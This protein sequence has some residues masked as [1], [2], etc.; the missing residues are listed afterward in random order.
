MGFCWFKYRDCMNAGRCACLKVGL[1]GVLGNLWG[2][3][4]K[5]LQVSVS[6]T[7][8]TKTCLEGRDWGHCLWQG[9]DREKLGYLRCTPCSVLHCC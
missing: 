4:A 5:D 1:E 3:W 6:L 7:A 2:L 8:E 9:C